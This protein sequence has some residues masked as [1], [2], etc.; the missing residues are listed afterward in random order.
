MVESRCVIR[1]IS[2]PRPQRGEPLE[3]AQLG[4]G[5]ERGGGLV[6]DQDRRV[7]QHRAR[8]REPLALPGRELRAALAEQRVVA[9][10]QR[11]D[12]LV[13]A[14]RPRLPR[15][16][17]RRRRRAPRSGCCRAR[18][19]RTAGSP[20]ARRRC[21]RAGCRRGSGAGRR[22]RSGC[23]RRRGRRGGA[24]APS[25][26]S[27]PSRSARRPPPR[28][29]RAPRSPRPRARG[30]RA[31]SGSAPPRS[32]RCGESAAAGSRPVPAATS[33]S[34]SSSSNTRSRPIVTSCARAPGAE[35]A[36][37]R[38]GAV[39][40]AELEVV[41]Q[42]ERPGRDA[43]GAERLERLA[44]R[45]EQRRGAGGEHE[46]GRRH[47]EQRDGEQAEARARVEGRGEGALGWRPR[48]GA[49]RRPRRR[50]P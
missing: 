31:D 17:R 50:T 8:D 48:S 16:R 37:Q 20:G 12:E 49:A 27:C 32:A 10:G 36:P 21:P 34:R 35:R 19:R 46:A 25:A 6:E 18:S 11:G 43:G 9:L 5:V 26:W 14:R 33:G 2:R 15:A 7:L 13:G 45:G 29:P 38:A 42:A 41:E 1:K 47:P 4:L 23:A 30:D 44:A 3:H 39:A 22:R 28:C 40:E 24:A